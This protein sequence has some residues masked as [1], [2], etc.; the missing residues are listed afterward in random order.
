EGG[1][2]LG[3]RHQGERIALLAD[4]V[5][6]HEAVGEMRIREA[7]ADAGRE[8]AGDQRLYFEIHA[9][10]ARV[11]AVRHDLDAGDGRE[12]IELDVVP[13]NPIERGAVAHATAD[14]ALDA[15]FVVLRGIRDVRNERGGFRR[16]AAAERWRTGGTDL[17]GIRAAMAEALRPG[18]VDPRRR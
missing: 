16:L 18:C 7:G 2:E 8:P 17:E 9:L 13:V 6:S 10:A 12:G 4:E 14:L 3:P 1:R 5:G 15:D 11:L